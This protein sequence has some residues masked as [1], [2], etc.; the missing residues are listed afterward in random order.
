MACNITGTLYLIDGTPAANRTIEFRAAKMGVYP[1]GNGGVITEIFTTTT[2]GSGAVNFDLMPG[3]Y[4]VSA[5]S[6]DG[7][8]P[9]GRD[10]ILG[11]VALVPD[12]ASANIHDVLTDAPI[13]GG[14]VQVA[15]VKVFATDAEAIAY[16]ASNMGAIVFSTE[17][18]T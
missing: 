17:G 7:V 12:Q 14:M 1:A 3:R 16:S 5:V 18:M 15:A 13:V 4:F 10:I 11:G 8:D 9:I 6:R 2:D